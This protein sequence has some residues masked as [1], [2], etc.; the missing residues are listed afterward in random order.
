MRESGILLS[1][2][3]LPGPEGVGTLGA[4]AIAFAGFLQQSGMRIW[5]MLPLGPTGYG[6]SPYQSSSMYAGNPLLISVETLR[7]EGLLK[8]QESFE[9]VDPERV[10]YDAVRAYKTRM[11]RLCFSQSGQKMA[12]ETARFVKKNP[13]V[14]DFALFTALKEHFGGQMWNRW[15]DRAI[16]DR[17]G[18]ALRQ[19]RAQL[20][21]EIRFHTFCQMLFFRQW[22]A[23]HAYCRAQG[24]ALFGDMPIYVAEDSADTWTNPRVFQL[25]RNRLPKRVAGVPPDYFSADGQMWG[26]PLYRWGLMRLT[27]Y[28]WWVNRMRHM[29]RMFD[30]V[31]IDHF[32]GFANYFSIAYGAPNARGGK[33]VIGPGESLFRVFRRKLP[34]LRIVA[35]DLGETNERV[36]KLLRFTGYPGMK[37][38]VFG[39]GGG[40]DNPH[41]PGNYGE[42]CVAYTGTHD[43]DTV[44]GWAKN[45]DENALNHARAVLHFDAVEDAPAAFVRC[46]M[47]SPADTAILAMQDVLGLDN[48]ARMNLPST[49]GGNWSWRMRP[50]QTTERLAERLRILNEETNRR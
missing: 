9:T 32:I 12:E 39:F 23:L 6:D 10:D 33:W 41:F 4:E 49:V 25:D 27:G 30:I 22:E 17:K 45:A 14:K 31:R 37:V 2:T 18:A 44:L 29:A 35:E 8:T 16:R 38:L 5:Q 15:P 24:I 1:V 7:N 36:Q 28:R 13:W 34:G 19:Y 50:G 21:G 48:S 26:N 46:V 20:D 11:L 43:N 3:S 42:N 40:E 47:A